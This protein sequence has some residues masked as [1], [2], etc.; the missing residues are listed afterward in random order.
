[1]NR[2]LIAML[3]VF[4]SML[5]TVPVR[6]YVVPSWQGYLAK[7][8]WAFIVTMMF[9]FIPNTS[10]MSVVIAGYFG[11]VVL[12]PFIGILVSMGL[13]RLFLGKF[14]EKEDYPAGG[15]ASDLPLDLY[16]T[17]EGVK[18]GIKNSVVPYGCGCTAAVVIYTI[19]TLT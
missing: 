17:W 15:G 13:T 5:P 9:L 11:I 1:M 6:I 4:V 8:E 2:T 7:V 14:P 16:W 12:A 10:E 3:V 19:L 18:Y